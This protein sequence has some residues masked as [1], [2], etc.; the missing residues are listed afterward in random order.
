MRASLAA[1]SK[2]CWLAAAMGARHASAART[3]SGALTASSPRSDIDA[4]LQGMSQCDAFSKAAATGRRWLSS[5]DGQRAL[6]C[7]EEALGVA[8]AAQDLVRLKVGALLTTRAYKEAIMFCAPHLPSAWAAL[9]G[10]S[11]RARGQRRLRCGADDTRTLQVASAAAAGRAQSNIE[12]QVVDPDLGV[13]FA[14]VLAQ[15]Q[16]ALL[17]A[18]PSRRATRRRCTWTATTRAPFASWRRCC[19][20]QRGTSMPF[21]RCARALRRVAAH[22]QQHGGAH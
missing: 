16:Q 14:K 13:L 21:E 7:A 19:R 6:E 5:G 18:H 12:S 10:A 2:R 8:P 20:Q 1:T 15:P 9:A 17:A 11:V 3:A 22:D 4:A